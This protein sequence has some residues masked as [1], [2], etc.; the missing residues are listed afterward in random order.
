MIRTSRCSRWRTTRCCVRKPPRDHT[1]P[2]P[3]SGDGWVEA[4]RDRGEAFDLR[5]RRSFPRNH[6]SGL[7]HAALRSGRAPSLRCVD[8]YFWQTASMASDARCLR[9]GICGLRCDCSVW[10]G[11]ADD[12][13]HAR[14]E[15]PRAAA[16]D[17][18]GAA[19]LA[20][21]L[22]GHVTHLASDVG[23]QHLPPQGTR[24]GGEYA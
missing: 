19:T 11:V 18:G 5:A 14:R 10:R 4:W 15:P 12:D 21:E 13:Q 7:K 9:C 16:G 6:P 3:R 17:D 24:R 8:V 20:A 22:K 2:R 23:K 1:P